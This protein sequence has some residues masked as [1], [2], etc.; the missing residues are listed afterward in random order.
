MQNYFTTEKRIVCNAS[1]PTSIRATTQ[2]RISI[3]I[4]NA[5]GKIISSPVNN[6]VQDSGTYEFT[7]DVTKLPNGIYFARIEVGNDAL[8]T[9][10]FSVVK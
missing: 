4:M 7:Y 9:I 6:K 10:R 8:Q 3:R 2:A 5:E 1:L